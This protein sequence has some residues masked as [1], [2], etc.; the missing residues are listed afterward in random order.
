MAGPSLAKHEKELKLLESQLE[1][2]R[3]QEHDYKVQMSDLTT[4]MTTMNNHVNSL[5]D[6]LRSDR[7]DLTNQIKDL[8]DVMKRQ[9]IG[10]NSSPGS[11]TRNSASSAN[12]NFTPH[13]KHTTTAHPIQFGVTIPPNTSGFTVPPVFMQSQPIFTQQPPSI[14]PHTSQHPFPAT[15][16]FPTSTISQNPIPQFPY[17]ANSI[18][19]NPQPHN[20]TTNTTTFRSGLNVPYKLPKV[21]FPKFD[22]SNARSWVVKAGKFFMLNPGMDEPTKVIFASLYLEGEADNWFQTVQHQHGS[23]TWKGF[24]NQLLQRFSSGNQENLVGRFNKLTQTGTVKAYIA[25]FEELRGYVMA[26]HS[27][28]TDEFYLSSFLSGLRAD[29][30]QALYVYKPRSLSEAMEKAKEQE[31]FMELME[32][33]V[34]TSVPRTT[35]TSFAAAK[36]TLKTAHSSPV[37]KWPE[38]K[39]ISPQEMAKRRERGLCYNCD[40]IYTRG[41]KCI[42]PQ[43]FLMVGDDDIPDAEE[44]PVMEIDW[45]PQPDVGV[46]LHALQGTQGLHTLKLD[47]GIKNKAIT[48]LVDTGS[49]HNFLSQALVKS[50]RIATIP[51]PEVKITLADGSTTSCTRKAVNLQWSAGSTMFVSDFYVLPLGGYDSI[52]GIQ[53]LQ[54][55]SPVCFDFAANEISLKWQGKRVTLKQSK[56]LADNIGI[57][58]DSEQLGSVG[59]Q[60]CFLVQLSAVEVHEQQKPPSIVIPEL[61]KPIIKAFPQVFEAPKSLPPNRPQ[62]HLIPIVEGSKPVNLNPYKCPFLQKTEIEKMVKEMLES[63]IIKHSQSPYASP[64]LLV[65]KKDNTWRFCVDYRA[66]NAITIK[67]RFPI[68]LIEDMLDQL[69]GSKMFTKLDLRSGYHQIRVSAQDTHKTAFKT[70]LGHYEFLV[71][72]FG[73]TN[74]PATFQCVMN[75]VFREHIGKFVCVFFDDILIYSETPE[76]HVQHLKTVFQIL[77]DNQL[78]VKLNKCAF[79]Q[80]KVEYLGYVIGGEGVEADQSKIAAMTSWPTPTTVKSLRGFLG[81]TGYYRRFVR[82][83]GIISKPLTNLLKKGAFH[84]TEETQAAFEK[85]KTAMCQ[86][87]VMGIPNF[88]K[89]FVVETDA[90]MSGAGA[91]LMQE[92]RP[93]SFFSK[94]FSPRNMGLSTYEKELLAVV[95]AVNKWRGYLLGRPFVIKTDQEAIKHLL[96]QKITTL[97]Q[98]KWLTKLLGFDYSIVY[99]KGKDNVVADPLSRLHEAQPDKHMKLMAVTLLIPQ[100]K[101]ELRNTWEQDPTYKDII[102]QLAVKPSSDGFTLSNGDL[103]YQDRLVVGQTGNYRNQ[104]FNS[105]HG[106]PEGGHSG[107]HTTIKRVSSL[108]WWPTLSQD[109]AK[110]VRS[111]EVCQRCK[112]EHVPYPGLLQ[113]LPVP[114]QAWDTVTMDFI[115]SLPK[116]GGKNT[117]LVII[118][119]YTKFAHMLALQHPFSATQVAQLLLDNVFKL[120]GP[121][122]AIITDRDKIFTSNFWSELFKKLGSVSKLTTAYHPQSDGQSERL[123]QCIELYLRC[124][125]YQR[126]H[127]WHRWL[128]MA[129]WWYNTSHHSAIGMT[130]YSA[131]Y[132]RQAPSFN[133]HQAGKSSNACVNEFIQQRTELHKLIKSNLQKAQE[134]MSLYANKHRTERNFEE[135]DEVFLKLQAFKQTSLKTIKDN[136]FTPKYFGPYKILKKIGAVAYRL[137][138]PPAAKIH[139]TFHVSLLKKKVGTDAIV[140]I[141]P[142]LTIDLPQPVYPSKILDTT[143]VHRRNA[144]TISVLVQWE[145][146]APEDASWVDLDVLRRNFPQFVAEDI[147][148]KERGIVTN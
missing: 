86:T 19:F 104:I 48:M 70:P 31:V 71:M 92:G 95:L 80:D 54:Q 25:E 94:A 40:E 33:R 49:T 36:D 144:T 129:E 84:W 119:K 111:C 93:L 28:H 51:S 30:Q 78:C 43:L 145:G 121:P 102:T 17:Q 138:L 124:L 146:M 2:V 9:T 66:L 133:Y 20:H 72:P 96:S 4:Q 24:V 110:W 90:C 118:D 73:L 112:S 35:P 10:N 122:K 126:P 115:E 47:G 38:V 79:A 85:L 23:F 18:G 5:K 14:L 128:A 140:Q 74:A 65:K 62:D 41:H 1:D 123:N 137:Q 77:K 97:M 22:G 8:V 50:Q 101:L 60:A 142:P 99:K 58:L 117:I 69:H 103:R 63:G 27:S 116:S 12:A 6:E 52:L 26:R 134:R 61:V 68:P 53:W 148:A 64:V 130:P 131:L 29:I 7:Q 114:D 89:N 98:Q 100:W 75:E 127:N 15:T 105:L 107:I 82:G 32:K 113:P 42:K 67:N 143:S 125:T 39:K 87:P 139:N 16:M 91:V 81:L 56:Q 106:S 34:R 108:F 45:A 132:G 83:Y 13:L 76:T 120:Y 55:V 136:K 46:S 3:K 11:N 135:G 21:D 88:N 141:D 37:A 147:S 44:E 59:E 109:I 57:V